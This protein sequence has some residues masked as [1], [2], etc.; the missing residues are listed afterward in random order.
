MWPIFKYLAGLDIAKAGM[1]ATFSVMLGAGLQPIFGVFSDRGAQRA[2]IL[3]GVGMAS[4]GMLLG[5]ASLLEGR[6]PENAWYLLMLGI[7]VVV[8][9]GQGMYHP[10]A[11]SAAGNINHGR[12]STLVSLFI[13]AGMIGFSVSHVLFS[14]VFK[15]LHAHT[16]WMLIPAGCILLFGWAWCRPVNQNV[17]EAGK[18]PPRL[19]DLR[20][21][22]LPLVILFFFE[23]LVG[24]MY[25][26]F[27]FLMPEFL[28]A[29]HRPDWMVNGGGVL[30]WVGGS[31]AIMI[32]AGHL[33]DRR[34]GYGILAA[35]TAVALALYYVVVVTPGLPFWAIPVLL[36]AAGGAAG[37]VN[38][39]G[40]AIGQHLDPRQA[41]L[42]SGILMG[43]AWATGS[44]AMWMVGALAKR[45]AIGVVGALAILGIAGVAGLL[46]AL[47]LPSAIG[48]TRRKSGAP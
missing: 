36:F 30:F 1:I 7:M 9:V 11:T 32:P 39:M 5:P 48:W 3:W 27:L 38:P 35:F 45:E 43:L 24:G 19:R 16:E 26:G 42:I 28:E 4:F 31:A 20:P 21:I 17:P 6:M 8:C 41:S 14:A 46:L 10:S 47:S 44:P 40:V 33:A 23:V 15:A 29:S 22:A 12:R 37:A 13:A 25:H 2:L 34:G 18:P